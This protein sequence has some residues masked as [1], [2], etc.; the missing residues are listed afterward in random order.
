MSSTE[1]TIIRSGG[2]VCSNTNIWARGLFPPSATDNNEANNSSNQHIFDFQ[3]FPSNTSLLI[4][5]CLNDE[6]KIKFAC[7]KGSCIIVSTF[8][9]QSIIS[10]Q[11]Q[12]QHSKCTPLIIQQTVR[13]D[14]SNKQRTVSSS[15]LPPSSNLNL[16]K[17]RH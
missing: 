14:K 2:F 7:A 12:Q 6:N 11:Q 5:I 17:Y 1:T 16:E 9:C 8:Q 15:S 10:P 3:S 13:S 4:D